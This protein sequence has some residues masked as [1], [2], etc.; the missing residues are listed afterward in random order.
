MRAELEQVEQIEKYLL[1][2]M[3]A[4]EKVE[5]ESHMNTNEQLKQKVNAQQAVVGAIRRMGVKTAAASAYGAWKLR[6]WLMRAS[7]S[8]LIAGA[9]FGSWYAWTMVNSEED[10]RDCTKI[11]ESRINSDAV[12]DH[13]ALPDNC[14][15]SYEDYRSTREV[16]SDIQ[17]DE[18]HP[19]G[20]EL[21]LDTC[22]DE[23]PDSEVVEEQSG[24]HVSNSNNVVINNEGDD[25]GVTSEFENAVFGA[26]S[27]SVNDITESEKKDNQQAKTYQPDDQLLKSIQDKNDLK[28]GRIDEQPGFPGGESALQEYLWKN[29]NYPLGA[30]YRKVEGTVY[31]SFTISKTGDIMNTIVVKSV[32]RELDKEAKRV[33]SE[34]P[35]WEP[36]K[37]DGKP[38]DL[39]Y[40]IPVQ[41][42]LGVPDT[43]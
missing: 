19:F 7:V 12:E 43:L 28:N 41:F 27:V 11:Y 14:C 40:T 29:M 15:Q 34:M 20:F 21:I 10:C 2:Q 18:F 17:P 33:V 37:R 6:R 3:S 32:D 1:N 39:R 8:I 5:F 9:L 31:V 36:G 38:I 24:N 13:A 26:D 35:K 16:Q 25:I 23:S 22:V 30:Q 4:E 42:I